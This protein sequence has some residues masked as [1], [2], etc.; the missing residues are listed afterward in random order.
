MNYNEL[1]EKISE[2]LADVAPNVAQ[3]QSATDI[4]AQKQNMDDLVNQIGLQILRQ[5]G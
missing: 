1:L 3:K 2:Q 5:G 4:Y